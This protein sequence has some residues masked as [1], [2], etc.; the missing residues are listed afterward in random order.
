[1]QLQYPI[2]L[3]I[4]NFEPFRIHLHGVSINDIV[5]YVLYNK[6]QFAYLS[7]LNSNIELMAMMIADSTAIILNVCNV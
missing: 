2:H 5:K 7:I 1:M 4:Y 3:R 6:S